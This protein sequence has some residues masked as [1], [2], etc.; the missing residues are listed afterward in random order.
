MYYCEP[1]VIDEI[2]DK[3]IT[4]DEL[5][6]AVINLKD[7]KAVGE[8]RIPIECYKYGSDNLKLALVNCFNNFLNSSEVHNE[9]KSIIIS[10]FKKGDKS[11][12]SN[13]RGISLI[14]SSDKILVKILYNRLR[15]WCKVNNILTELQAGFR[16][17]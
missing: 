2:L 12:A 15:K 5:N 3:I 11:V 7:K 6:E 17:G 1:F 4:L 14:N 10:L 9:N 16:E 13:Y 8:D